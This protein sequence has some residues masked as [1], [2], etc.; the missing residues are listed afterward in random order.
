[1]IIH[2]R[3]PNANTNAT[4]GYLTVYMLMRTQIKREAGMILYSRNANVNTYQAGDGHDTSQQ[5]R[6]KIKK[7]KVNLTC[8][9]QSSMKHSRTSKKMESAV[10]PGHEITQTHMK[11]LGVPSTANTDSTKTIPLDGSGDSRFQII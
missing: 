7:H 5:K 10:G 9:K 1:M 4:G 8:L 11:I 2:N 6:K 3:K